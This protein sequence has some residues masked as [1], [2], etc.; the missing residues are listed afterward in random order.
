MCALVRTISESQCE[1]AVG[2]GFWSRKARSDFTR[3]TSLS[4][5]SSGFVGRERQIKRFPV[6]LLVMDLSP[7]ALELGGLQDDD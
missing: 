6:L 7:L 3:A 5:P 2:L 1:L 4:S